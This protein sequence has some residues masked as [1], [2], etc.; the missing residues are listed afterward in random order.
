MPRNSRSFPCC[1]LL[2]IAC[3][4]LFPVTVPRLLPAA[5]IPADLDLDR[6]PAT[7]YFLESGPNP[8][9]AILC[10]TC[11][12]GANV[13]YDMAK[14]YGL[15]FPLVTEGDSSALLCEECHEEVYH[16][17]HPVNFAVKDLKESIEKAAVFPLETLV[18]GYDKLTCATCHDVHYPHTRNRLLRG[19]A[20]S[21]AD[22]DSFS[23][24]NDFCRACHGEEVRSIA[25]HW[26]EPP[27]KKCNL[28]HLGFVK[29]GVPGP[30]KRLVNESCVV[31]HPLPRGERP[32]YYS[33]NP[34][35]DF[36]RSELE[37][38][39]LVLEKGLFTCTVCHSHHRP[40]K[41]DAFLRPGFVDL[42]SKS[43]RVNPHRTTKFC[44]NCHPFTPPP[45]GTEGAAAPLWEED[46]TRLC[47]GCH[48]KEGALKMFHP[49][50]AP[51]REGMVPEGWTLR[52]DGT[53]GCQTCHLDGHG[54][55]DPIN[56][57]MLRDG[58]GYEERNEICFKCHN[59][60]DYASRNIHE[61]I[62]EFKGCELCHI[63]KERTALRPEGKI[64][65]LLAEPSLLCLF[66]HSPLPHPA[67]ADHTGKPQEQ[68]F[69]DL[70]VEIT[71]LTMEKV[72]CH[73]CHDSHAPKIE[74]NLLRRAG[75]DPL[76]CHNCHPF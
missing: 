48:S 74:N 64:G 11:H 33:Y 76:V 17:F 25:A 40:E 44:Q 2:W 29:P 14:K 7:E 65:D 24:R 54:P 66:C 72:T 42:V 8:H 69:V 18:E 67:S 15:T 35:P 28:C 56:P 59:R 6:A 50:S 47:R 58:R 68:S 31:C 36:E 22:D 5:S 52:R 9:D 39:G 46:V 70:N 20:V 60:D 32:H 49:L 43:I 71:P 62:I 3:A 38:Y 34:F 19:F 57:K 55:R 23:S 37:G 21:P 26:E 27:G 1:F 13:T 4:I 61:E 75:R 30:L 73:T 45:V 53:L 63:V 51:T 16:S 12:V 10:T 41:A